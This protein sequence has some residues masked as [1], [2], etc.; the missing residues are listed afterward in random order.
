MDEKRVVVLVEDDFHDRL[1]NDFGDF[2]FLGSL[3]FDDAMTDTMALD[4]VL[5]LDG[6]VLFHERAAS[7]QH[8]LLIDSNVGLLTEQFLVRDFQETDSLRPWESCCGR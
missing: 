7:N 3:H 6:K 2:D 5:K 4:E 1:H 8:C